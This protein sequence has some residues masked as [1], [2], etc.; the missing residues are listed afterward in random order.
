MV[1]PMVI[2]L[3]R[4]LPSGPGQ[5]DAAP[6]VSRQNPTSTVRSDAEHLARNRKVEGASGRASPRG[7]CRWRVALRYQLPRWIELVD[8]DARDR[9]GSGDD[10]RTISR[11]TA[12]TRW[13]APGRR[14][15]SGDVDSGL[16]G[17]SV[18]VVDLEVVH[19]QALHLKLLDLEPPH[20]RTPDRQPPDR[21][22]ADGA[23]PDRRRPDR[24]RA[25]ADRAELPRATAAPGRGAEWK[26]EPV[27]GRSSSD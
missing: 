6:T 21:Q 5:A 16:H 19:A 7:P 18:L 23:G 10:K 4:L 22:G 12:R 9:G 3:I 11:D 20:D 17:G 2:Q 14:P 8:R 26:L 24:E 25:N 15:G 13:S 27:H 1:I